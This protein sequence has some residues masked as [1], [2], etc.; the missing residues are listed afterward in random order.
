MGKGYLAFEQMLNINYGNDILFALF[1]G[2]DIA[3]QALG[4]F[5]FSHSLMD[6][7]Y[8]IYIL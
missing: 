1:A 2:G 6:I 3:I 7:T 8:C 5:C 4:I